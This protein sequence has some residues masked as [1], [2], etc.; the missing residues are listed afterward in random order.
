M[1]NG[2]LDKAKDNTVTQIWSKKR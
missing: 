1:E 2:F